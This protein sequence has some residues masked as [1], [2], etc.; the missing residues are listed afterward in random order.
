VRRRITLLA[1]LASSLAV[2][3]F[4]VPLAIAVARYLASDERNELQR[5]AATAAAGVS[6]DLNSTG[7]SGRAGL[8]AGAQLTVYGPSGTRISGPGPVTAP[9]LVRAALAGRAGTGT[10]RGRLIAAA[11]VSDGDTVI[12]AVTVTTTIG[13]LY[14]RIGIAWTE[15]VAVAL[16]AIAVTAI[17]AGRYGRGLSTPLEQLADT[18]QR[19]G[20]GQRGTLAAPSRIPE[21]DTVARALNDSAGRL[22]TTI[23]RERQFTADASHQLRTPLAGLRLELETALLDETADNR[24]AIGRAL[25]AT[26]HLQDT[27][28]ALLSIGRDLPGTSCI[29]LDDTL[30]R[31]RARWTGPLA[32]SNRPLH[33]DTSALEHNL[34]RCAPGALD[35]ILDVLLDNAAR[36]GSGAV[37]V[38]ARPTS[39]SLAI[40]VSNAGP[41]IDT[42]SH[43]LFRRRTEHCTGH[44][45][46]LALARSL[47][48][49][50][51][52]R[53]TLTSP[54]PPTFTLLLPLGHNPVTPEPK[55]STR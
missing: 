42:P 20:D 6:G 45:I 30:T 4:A 41:A 38:T 44:G 2:L 26:D 32:A 47:A 50:D 33:T 11:P 7:V 5:S 10:G 19:L 34:V 31:L 8:E 48:E 15:M 54:H 14:T 22:H 43:E 12:G 28:E 17:A 52:G 16:A 36:H 18:A 23:D 46:G 1:V 35:Q 39:G 29:H 13:Q 37:T 40:D 53:L 49:A 27:I 55:T 9:A 25:A 21:L 51:G 3:L 24:A